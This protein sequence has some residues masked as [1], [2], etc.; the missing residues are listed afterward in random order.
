M[1]SW[2]RPDAL[3][4]CLLAL[5]AQAA[6]PGEVIVAVRDDD[7]ETARCI[8]GLAP[9]FP[10]PLRRAATGE[11]GVIAA[12]NAA[13]ALATGEIVALTDDDAEPRPDWTQRLVACFADPRVGG[14]GGRDWQPH[15]RDDHTDVG[16]VQWF[17]R[18]IGNHHLGS[19]PA[20][21]VDV[22]KGVNCA[23]R[24]SLLRATGFDARLAGEGAQMFWELALCL[25]LRRA[26]WTLVYDPA[27]AVEHHVAP[28][29]EADQ[30]HRG[31]FSSGPQADAVHN[32]TLVLLEHQRGVARMAFAAWALAVGTRAEPGL[33]QLPRLALAGDRDALARWRSTMAGRW[34]GWITYRRNDAG[35]VHPPPA[36]AQ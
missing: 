36:P 24:A 22:L 15:E 1:P 2:H 20:R 25:P 3:R 35:A 16:R 11:R 27:I 12:M 19:G 6:A 9:S 23:F 10:V 4:R 32:E 8:A 29:H 34:R 28:R 33:L 17:G 5:A 21:A 7:E 14:A 26:G 13:L 30:R 18:V 31:L